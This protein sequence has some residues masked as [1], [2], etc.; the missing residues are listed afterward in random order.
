MREARGGRVP[1]RDGK[2]RI[3]AMPDLLGRTLAGLTVGIVALVLLDGTVELF[4]LGDFGRANGWL[5]LI[6]PAW[7]FVEEF[8]ASAPGPARVLAAVVSAAVAVALGLVAAGLVGGLP[9]L[10]S[11]AIAAA[12]AALSYAI[13]WFYGVRWLDNR[14]S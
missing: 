5:A 1:R 9:P 13:V 14:M 10:A 6:L 2:G 8:R 3:E 7:L 11:G 12:V 4:G